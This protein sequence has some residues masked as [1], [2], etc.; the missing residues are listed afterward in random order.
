MAENLD[1]AASNLLC[2]ENTNTCFGDLDYNAIN[3]F[4]ISHSLHPQQNQTH[5][6]DPF[7]VNNRSGSL[8]GFDFPV[9]SEERVREMVER[10]IE[11]LPRDDYL[12]RLRGGDLDLRVR[13]EA[14]DWIWKACGHYHFEPLSVCLSVNYLDRFLSLYELPKGKTWTGQLLAVACLSVAAKMEETK[15]PLSVDLQVGESK[16]FFEAK[17]I[18]RME[19]LL[20]ST[21][22]WKMHAFTPCSFID[23]FLSKIGDDHHPSP[24]SISRSVQL[25]LSTMKGIDFLE[26]RPSEIAA[27]VAISVSGT[28]QAVDIDKAISSFVRVEKERVLKCVELMKDLSLISGS[29]SANNVGSTSASCVPQSPNGVLDATCLSYKSDDITVGSCANSS[30]CNQDSKRRKQDNKPPSHVEFKS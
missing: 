12:K 30:H 5:N 3:K 22:R 27:G 4:E 9:P 21:L 24:T 6:E 29:V 7:F 23:Y 14:L 18:Q 16:F 15:V 13:R 11:H 1:C 26:F 8:M 20:L 17:T 10:E 25:I 28:M 2:A 19:L